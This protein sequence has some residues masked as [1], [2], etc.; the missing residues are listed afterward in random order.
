MARALTILALVASPIVLSAGL[1]LLG[2]FIHGV[3]RAFG[4]QKPPT[5]VVFAMLGLAVLHAGYYLG[6]VLW[7]QGR[8]SLALWLMTPV[9]VVAALAGLVVFVRI[10]PAASESSSNVQWFYGMLAGLVVAAAAYATPIV[11]MVRS[12]AR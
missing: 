2:M 7:A 6:P 1:V 3:G 4:S 5:P 10:L 11:I 12:A 8:A 9:A